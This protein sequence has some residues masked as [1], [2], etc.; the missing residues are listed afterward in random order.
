MTIKFHLDT[1]RGV[2]G[3]RGDR[4]C[5]V[6]TRPLKEYDAVQ[7]LLPS[8]LT[9]DQHSH[10]FKKTE[11]QTHR[12]ISANPRPRVPENLLA[13]SDHGV[14]R[15]QILVNLRNISRTE[16]L[17]AINQQSVTN[18]GFKSLIFGAELLVGLSTEQ[19]TADTKGDVCGECSIA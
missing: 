13:T 16:I 1:D 4:R 15:Q 3:G 5:Q 12:V 10:G 17:P 7:L 9:N 14:S 11:H 18:A 2:K 8:G 6:A 19:M